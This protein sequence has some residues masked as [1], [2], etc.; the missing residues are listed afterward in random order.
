MI[1]NVMMERT[2]KILMLYCWTSIIVSLIIVVLFETNMLESGAW[3][4]D[5]RL[6]F[7]AAV[8][9]ELLLLCLA[10][11]ALY[12]FRIPFVRRRLKDNPVDSASQLLLWG[13]LR[14]DMLVLPMIANTLFYYLFG[15]NVT[16]GYM[17]IILL[18]CL[19]L[20]YPSKRRCMYEVERENYGA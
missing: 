19:L 14:M 7:T 3:A 18:L 1:N 12:L 15:L 8:V 10:P 16:F 11:L 2:Q 20:V 9:M 6:F 5:G 13:T 4:D 17:A